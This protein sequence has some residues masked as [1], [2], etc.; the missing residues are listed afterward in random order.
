MGFQIGMVAA[1]AGEF[2][3]VA[4][5]DGRLLGGDAEA[6]EV[7]AQVGVLLSDDPVFDVGFLGELNDRQV[8]SGP[9]RGA[10]EQLVR[11]REDLQPL[12]VGLD[13]VPALVVAGF[14]PLL[15]R[16]RGWR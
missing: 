14:M 7:V 4:D 9:D 12:R 1:E 3:V 10:S 11:G 15:G 6:L 5:R 2:V 13:G 8:A 16:C